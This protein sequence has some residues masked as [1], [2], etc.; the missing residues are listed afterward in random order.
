[1]K[2]V[3]ISTSDKGGA[4]IAAVRL[5]TALLSAGIES[6]L[7]TK[8]KFVNDIKNHFTLNPKSQFIFKLLDKI[9]ITKK[10]SAAFTLKHLANRPAGFEY[11]SFPYSVIDIANHPSVILADI[12]HL[13]W[14]SDGFL[15]FASFFEK[16]NKPVVWTLHDMNPFTGGCHHSDDCLGFTNSCF[17]CVQLKGTIDEGYADVILRYKQNALSK[18][19]PGKIKIIAPSQW[20][21]KRSMQSVLFSR[22]QHQLI[23]NVVDGEK[24]ILLDRLKSR[25]EFNLPFDKRIILFVA[26]D[27][28]NPRKGI[29]YLKH[30]MEFF[31]HAIVC[32]IGKNNSTLDFKN[33]V[34][35]GYITDSNKLA[36]L[37][38]AV[39]VF[40]LPSLAENFPNTICE[41]LLCGTPVVGF[42]IG[43]IPELINNNNGRLAVYKDVTSLVSSIEEIFKNPEKFDRIEIRNAALKMFDTSDVVKNHLEIYNSF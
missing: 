43:G 16:L 35:M 32:G 2:V 41:S 31:P 4:G 13:H 27:I 18:I 28:D 25:T 42:D 29:A 8:Y 33:F 10:G 30:A 15:D 40:V 24:F 34:D 22:F 26:N 21:L 17:N 37:F 23:R 14:V 6:V 36:S 19:N 11:F 39:D 1:M 12:I 5:H 20:L 7:L 3:H 9:G 38:N